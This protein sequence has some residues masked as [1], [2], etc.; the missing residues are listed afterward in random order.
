MVTTSN[1]AASKTRVDCQPARSMASLIEI[2]TENS[3]PTGTVTVAC[4]KMS[5]G[6][7]NCPATSDGG[8]AGRST[9]D[10]RFAESG[11][12]ADRVAGNRS[13]KQAL[14][15]TMIKHLPAE[16]GANERK[17]NTRRLLN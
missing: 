8:Y 7:I 5:V 1:E 16:R 11:A 15:K 2:S 10:R 9:E 3:L 6:V 14:V 17:L 13:S 4:E 12:L